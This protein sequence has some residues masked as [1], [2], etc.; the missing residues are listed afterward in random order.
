V[1]KHTDAEAWANDGGVALIEQT[2]GVTAYVLARSEEALA[3]AALQI[4]Q[5]LGWALKSPKGRPYLLLY[6]F[7]LRRG[8][9]LC[10]KGAD[11]VPDATES[12]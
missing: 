11:A 1:L 5:K 4:Y 7:A 10:S 6:G 3:Q 12:G 2:D 8:L 9:E